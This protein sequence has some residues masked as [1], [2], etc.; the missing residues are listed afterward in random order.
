MN[1]WYPPGLDAVAGSANLLTDDVKVVLIGPGYVF[2]PEHDLTDLATYIIG[3]A[4]TTTGKLLVDGVL[5]VD[6][7][8]FPSVAGGDTVKGY[9]V[10]LDGSAL[11]VHV[12]TKPDTTAISVATDG[13]D[14]IVAPD[15]HNL[16]KV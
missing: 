9:V 1:Q 2:D 15:G 7:I 11:L 13:D 16:L 8:V 4:V 3:T 14:I 6:D 5:Q 10:Y 12:D